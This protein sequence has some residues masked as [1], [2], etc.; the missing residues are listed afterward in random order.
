M[1]TASNS[2]PTP[3]SRAI[4]TIR[5]LRAQLANHG[6]GQR[7]AVVGVGMR[8]PGAIDSLDAYWQLL[9]EARDM[10]RPMPA[11]RKAPFTADWD[12][13]PHR[14]GYLDDV[15]GFDAAF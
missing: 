2:P 8:F 10:V 14:G 7:I 5:R 11:A 13:L 1:D 15:T 4:D 3:L 6:T 12:A 9:A